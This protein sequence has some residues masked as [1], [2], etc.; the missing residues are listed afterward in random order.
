MADTL[1][2]MLDRL[3]DRIPHI[4][5][6]IDALRMVSARVEIA[7]CKTRQEV[8]DICACSLHSGS[9]VEKI[10]VGRAEFL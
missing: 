9:Q 7:R 2:H 1:A 8:T 4:E 10:V 3:P 6:L 5:Q